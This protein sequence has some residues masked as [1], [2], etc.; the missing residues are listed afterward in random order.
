M[1]QRCIGHNPA[2]RSSRSVA[3]VRNTPVIA[4]EAILCSDASL[5][6]TPTE[7]LVL[8]APSCLNI[9]VYHMSAAYVIL[10]TT[11]AQYSCRIISSLTPLNGLASLLNAKIHL[12]AFAS[13]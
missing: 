3:V 9:G 1:K 2:C 4:V 10:G 6:V 11:T 5:L 13:V 8:L 7:P 12:V